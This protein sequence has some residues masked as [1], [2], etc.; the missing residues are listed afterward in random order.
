MGNDRTRLMDGLKRVIWKRQPPSRPSA[1]DFGGIRRAARFRRLVARLERARLSFIAATIHDLENGRGFPW[2]VVCF[3]SGI[4]AYFEL[5][6]EPQLWAT[7]PLAVGIAIVA[8]VRR[9]RGKA[10]VASLVLASLALGLA[11]AN[12]RTWSVAA[13]R[14]AKERTVE[15][16]GWVENVEQ[17]ENGYRLTILPARIADVEPTALPVRIRVTGRALPQPLPGQAIS[18]RARLS[19]PQGPVMPGGYAF[20]RAAYF[21]RVGAYGFIYGRTKPAVL[22]MPA[23]WRLQITAAIADMRGRI[24][25]RIR[26]T[27]P[28]DAGAIAAALIVG[29]RGAVSEDSQE[30]LRIAG[31]AH[32]L[33]ISG[34]HMA[35]VAGAIFFVV[36]AGLALSPGLALRHPIRSW[37]AAAALVAATAYLVISGASIA[38]QRAYV[39]AAVIFIAMIAGRP[40]VT[41]RSVALAA[42]IV[43]T[44]TPEALLQPGFQM[45]FAAVI[46]LVAAYRVWFEWRKRSQ[47]AD[48]AELASRSKA[49]SILH[50]V[51]FWASGLAMTSL[52]AGFATGPIALSHFHR[53]S[54]LGLLANMAAMPLVSLLIMP[55]AVATVLAMPFGLDPLTLQPMGL[56][57]DGMLA[58][59]AKIAEWTP[60]SGVVGAIGDAPAI[61]SVAGLLWLALWTSRWR[62]LGILPI[63]AAVVVAF[64]YQR[65]DILVSEDGRTVAVRTQQ[66]PLA[67]ALGSGGK[68]EAE[69]WLR[70]DG[71]AAALAERKAGS[72]VMNC[73]E[74][75]C[76]IKAALPPVEAVSQRETPGADIIAGR[77]FGEKLA[78]ASRTASEMTASPSMAFSAVADKS[79]AGTGQF[80]WRIKSPVRSFATAETVPAGAPAAEREAQHAATPTHAGNPKR[81]ANAGAGVAPST[82]A[83]APIAS[84]PLSRTDRS[85]GASKR[86]SIILSRVSRPDAFAEDCLRAD[87]IVSHLTAPDD[88]SEH[89]LVF[90]GNYLAAHGAVALYLGRAASSSEPTARP[91]WLRRI[92]T[93]QNPAGRPWQSTPAQQGEQ[94]R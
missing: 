41:M 64:A 20:D 66:G 80:A 38:T 52:I 34:M 81:T 33:A 73:D 22:G 56:G 5:P 13:P 31:L 67:V 83:S 14:I 68:F 51:V 90:D 11:V 58:I 91:G 2:L 87:V 79:P 44:L 46:A 71:D 19:P 72:G 53:A 82:I 12:H 24:G 47:R 3:A 74:K 25:A 36:R 62:L 35:L 45:S 42:A 65:P 78:V 32:V 85:A 94:S 70:A 21:D 88:C 57:I 30:N 16:G 26:Q 17:R 15:V 43:L 84:E 18:F 89:A 28:G 59:A 55:F 29:D 37:A 54:P 48:A 49:A 77:R 86:I 50:F 1:Y 93:A 27:L 6:R 39:M 8:Q 75:A 40:A 9:M 61:L 4:W 92:V 10:A 63:A 76:I 60:G 69:I 7:V 23:S